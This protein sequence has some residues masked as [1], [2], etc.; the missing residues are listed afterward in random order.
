[1][2]TNENTNQEGVNTPVVRRSYWIFKKRL[3]CRICGY[4]WTETYRVYDMPKPDDKNL[5]NK[6]EVV[7][8][9]CVNL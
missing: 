9:H 8:Y 2:E 7:Q 3:M 5:R 6:F 1:M 4:E